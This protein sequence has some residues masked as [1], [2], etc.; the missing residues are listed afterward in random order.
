MITSQDTITTDEAFVRSVTHQWKGR[1]LKPFSAMRQA[2]AQRCGLRCGR[3]NEAEAEAFKKTGVYDGIM[4]DVVLV[5]FLCSCKESTV[6]AAMRDPES[7]TVDAMNWADR[8]GISYLGEGFMEAS[9]VFSKIMGD[10]F[11]SDF[12]VEQKT[13][14]DSDDPKEQGHHH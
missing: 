10:L 7:I 8:E 9:A 14:S 2:A 3:L 13:S 11:A 1:P 4:M 12:D 5:L 6:L